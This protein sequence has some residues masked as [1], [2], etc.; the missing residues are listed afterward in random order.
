MSL[1]ELKK[2]FSDG[3]SEISDEELA[4]NFGIDI[5]KFFRRDIFENSIYEK[6]STNSQSK[7]ELLKREGDK[8]FRDDIENMWN[9]WKLAF[10]NLYS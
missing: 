9:G 8:Y 10:I 3:L 7:E 4:E 2:V 5:V 1:D 6:Y